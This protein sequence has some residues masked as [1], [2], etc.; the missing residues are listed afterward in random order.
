MMKIGKIFMG[1]ALIAMMPACS[2]KKEAA[3]YE[4]PAPQDVVMYEVNPRTFAPNNSFQ[5]VIP[6]LDSIKSLG[7]NVVWIMPIYPIGKE[8]SKNSP[9]SIAD[10]KGVNPEFGTLEDFKTLVGE[11]HKRGM[12]FIMDWVANHTAWD[13]VWVREHPDWYTHDAEGNIICPEGTD[14]TDV[15][16]LNY[17][18]S[19]MRQAMIESMEYWIKEAGVDGFRCDVADQ[20]P[21]DFWKEAIDSL[22]ACAGRPI[23][24]LAD[25]ADSATFDAGFQLNYAWTYLGTLRNVFAHDSSAVQL[26]QADSAEYSN[27]PEGKFKLRFTTNHDEAAKNSTLGDYGGKKGALAAYVAAIFTRGAALIYGEQE[28]AYPDSINFFNYVP[29]DWKAN[30]DVR[31]EYRRLLS[32]FKSEPELHLGAPKSYT[33]HDVLMYEKDG[34]AA[35]YL[36]VVNVRDSTLAASVPQAWR[37]I[38]LTNLVNG[39]SVRIGGRLPLT[40][41]EYRIFKKETAAKTE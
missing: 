16:D 36:V 25:G 39:K 1:A 5:S 2:L 12:A 18:N 27:I 17:D 32:I 41:F 10:Y 34:K 7:T 20:V 9:Y 13:N 3:S 29:V 30:P 28:A 8:K 38:P 33:D 40:P 35:D 24:M 37:D 11:T 31:E 23:L 26:I 19:Q 21:S 15:A 22:K 14:W 4:V 6:Q